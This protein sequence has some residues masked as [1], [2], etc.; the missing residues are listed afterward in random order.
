[1]AHSLPKEP[2]WPQSD[3]TLYTV[4]IG[5]TIYP[6]KAPSGGEFVTHTAEAAELGVSDSNSTGTYVTEDRAHALQLAES[7]SRQKHR[8]VWVMAE[9]SLGEVQA[10]TIAHYDHEH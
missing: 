4:R 2:K 8:E 3:R 9:P 7:Y 10:R 1:M 6:P 5:E